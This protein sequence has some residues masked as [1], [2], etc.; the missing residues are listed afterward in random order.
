MPLVHQARE[1]DGNK[2]QIVDKQNQTAMTA[3]TEACFLCSALSTSHLLSHSV[4]THALA[5]E[6]LTSSSFYR[7]EK[8]RPREI[9]K[10]IQDT[11]AVKQLPWDPVIACLK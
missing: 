2:R 3:T 10:V 9:Q 5:R 6:T 8:R 11:M 7:K 4:L 1:N